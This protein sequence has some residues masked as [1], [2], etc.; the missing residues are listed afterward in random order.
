MATARLRIRKQLQ[1]EDIAN[2]IHE[3][4][5]GMKE[6]YIRFSDDGEEVQERHCLQR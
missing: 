3:T 6:E 5:A 1:N 4:I 2:A